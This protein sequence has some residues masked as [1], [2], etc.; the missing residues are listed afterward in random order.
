MQVKDKSVNK[1][2]LIGVL[3]CWSIATYLFKRISLYKISVKCLE[4][5]QKRKIKI[6]FIEKKLL[7]IIEELKKNIIMCM[8]SVSY[9]K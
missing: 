9:K 7:K 5:T 8:Y 1:K 4:K 6:I 2:N 3:I